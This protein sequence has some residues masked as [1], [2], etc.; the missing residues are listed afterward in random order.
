MLYTLNAP[1]KKTMKSQQ[2]TQ[3]FPINPMTLPK[4]EL[5]QLSSPSTSCG[6]KSQRDCMFSWDLI[7]IPD[8]IAGHTQH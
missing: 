2:S 6:I 1:P 5:G 4:K 7:S 8:L 3:S